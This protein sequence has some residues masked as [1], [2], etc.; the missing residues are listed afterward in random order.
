[1]ATLLA[2]YISSVIQKKASENMCIWVISLAAMMSVEAS[3]F[4]AS[5]EDL[6]NIEVRRGTCINV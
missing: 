4:L 5:V 3:Y 1:M 6:I 2:V